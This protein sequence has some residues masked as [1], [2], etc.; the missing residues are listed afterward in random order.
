MHLG[1][2]EVIDAVGI[3]EVIDAAGV[4]RVIDEI[5][6]DAVEAALARAKQRKKKTKNE[7]SA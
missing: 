7:R 2:K 1:L 4:D 6:I 3:K 5:G